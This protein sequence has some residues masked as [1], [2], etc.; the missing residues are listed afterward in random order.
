[1]G[2]LNRTEDIVIKKFLRETTARKNRKRF[3]NDF[4]ILHRTINVGGLWPATEVQFE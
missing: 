1:M 4:G 3:Y 2:V